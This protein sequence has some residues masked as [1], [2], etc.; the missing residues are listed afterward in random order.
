MLIAVALSC[1][2]SICPAIADDKNPDTND[3]PNA[4]MD[5]DDDPT[6]G[7]GSWIWASKTLD[8][9]TCQFWRSLEIPSGATVTHARLK[10]TVDNEYYLLL[11]G[12]DLGRGCEWHELFDYD[13][14]FLL[15]PGKHV[16]A[17]NAYNA[18]SFA[19]MIFG[20]QIDLA[21]GRTMEIKSDENWRI[22]PDGVQ[23]WETKT[24][25]PDTWMPATIVAPLGGSPWWKQPS[26]VNLMPTLLPIT[27]FFWQTGWFQI[28]LLSIC[29][30]AIVVSFRLIG[31]LA[32]HRRERW[33]LQKERARIARDIHDDLGSRMTQLVLH[34]EVAQSELPVESAMRSQL[35]RIC[36]DARE[37]LST[38]DEI[39]W[40]LNPKRDTFDDFASYVCGYAQG[41]LKSTQMQCLFD[42]APEMMAVPVELP[43]RRALLMAV[44]ETL[45]NAV[46]YSEATEVILHISCRA[47]KLVVVVLDNGKGFD[48]NKP[49]PGRNGLTYMAQRMEEVGG[50]CL[51]ASRP[52]QGCRVELSVP[53]NHRS[54]W[55]T[56]GWVLEPKQVSEQAAKSNPL[57]AN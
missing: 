9:Q 19:G 31:Q 16:L 37:V 28:S 34:G 7:L 18:S 47:Q 50:H 51:V 23:G 48:P 32:I 52:A 54:P 27:R 30:I 49:K 42:V 2:A 35:E 45:N 13:V 55:G 46:K 38:M 3:C 10:M 4:T 17:V 56:W 22:V 26:K 36:Q 21:D 15:S 11:D 24:E 33:L 44:K 8:R 5:V 29:A 57:E 20:L 12:R 40:G 6:K 1:L 53:L 41:F 14:T 43:F 25:A 39:L